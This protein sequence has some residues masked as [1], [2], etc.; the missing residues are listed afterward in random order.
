M[1]RRTAIALAAALTVFLVLLTSTTPASAQ[2]GLPTFDVVAL[3][4][5]IFASFPSFLQSI[6]GPIFRALISL[7]GGGCL[8]PF[9]AS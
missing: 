7:F 6:L 5:T 9:C 4:Q 2:L 1:P 8:P 3:L